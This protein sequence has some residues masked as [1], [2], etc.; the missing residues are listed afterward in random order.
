MQGYS[1]I[2]HHTSLHSKIWNHTKQDTRLGKLVYKV[3]LWGAHKKHNF[4]V[5]TCFEKYRLCYSREPS[6]SKLEFPRNKILFKFFLALFSF[7]LF[8]NF[9]PDTLSRILH[10]VPSALSFDIFFILSLGKLFADV[11]YSLEF[12]IFPLL[13]FFV[14]HACFLFGAAAIT[15]GFPHSCFSNVVTTQ[16]P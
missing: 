11:K 1:H 13:L 12:K 4:F 5:Q 9:A 16:L 10:I 14:W 8:F 15:F 2:I 6:F 7:A 3:S